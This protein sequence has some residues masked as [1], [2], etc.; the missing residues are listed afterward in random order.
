MAS[1]REKG[2]TP[3]EILFSNFALVLAFDLNTGQRDGEKPHG[4]RDACYIINP[5]VRELNITKT[6]TETELERFLSYCQRGCEIM[7]QAGDLKIEALFTV[8]SDRLRSSSIRYND[9]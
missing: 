7:N 1:P 6:V 3:G 2:V 5:F 4:D 9:F 8:L